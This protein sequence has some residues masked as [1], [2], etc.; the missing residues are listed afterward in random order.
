[1]LPVVHV[2]L[3]LRLDERALL[4][5]DDDVLEPARELADADR[6]ER[7]GHA[8]LVDAHADV[9]RF[10][11]AD[12]EIFERLQHVE[13]ALAGRDDAEPRARRIDH[14]AIDAVRA[15]ERDRGLHRVPVQTHFLIERRI[16]PADVETAGRQRE[17]GRHAR[18]RADAD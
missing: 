2:L 3:H 12:A 11:G 14:D 13:I 8:D 1:M 17:I 5:D 4:L 18:C 9:A 10:L 6:L 7:P 15:R 16:G